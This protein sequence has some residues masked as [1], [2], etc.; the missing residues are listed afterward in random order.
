[1]DSGVL[2][3]F[4]GRERSLPRLSL[5]YDVLRRDY[6]ED[7]YP[8]RP[9]FQFAYNTPILTPQM[10]DAY[11]AWA[12]GQGLD[13]IDGAH[14]YD[15]Q[16]AFLR[17]YEMPLDARVAE[18]VDPRGHGFDYF[19]KPNH[20]TFSSQSLRASALHPGGEWGWE[21]NGQGYSMPPRETPN[22]MPPRETAEY[23]RNY[24]PGEVLRDQAMFLPRLM[25]T[26]YYP[27]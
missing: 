20:S 14:D 17:E 12:R 7:M 21:W 27:R 18:A 11:S 9:G 10:W 6:P 4:D 2:D 1:M 25:F 23:M 13:P 22:F 16:G 19:K 24:E 26:D 3:Y 5:P 15:M 8:R